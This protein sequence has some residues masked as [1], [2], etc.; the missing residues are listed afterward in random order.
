[1]LPSDDF[2]ADMSESTQDA[3]KEL[4]LSSR[5]VTINDSDYDPVYASEGKPSPYITLEKA[6]EIALAQANVPAANAVF[7]DKEFDHDDGTPVFELEFT[8]NGI[9]IPIRSPRC[10]R[11]SDRGK[12]HH[13]GNTE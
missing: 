11:R 12:A 3:I 5:I 8:A 6:Q 7:A 4:K 13:H 2:L 1:M 10:D 9:K